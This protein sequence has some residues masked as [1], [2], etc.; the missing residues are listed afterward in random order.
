MDSIDVRPET[1]LCSLQFNAFLTAS[2]SSWMVELSGQDREVPEETVREL[3]PF[4]LLLQHGQSRTSQ[5]SLDTGQSV[6]TIS[7]PVSVVS[8]LMF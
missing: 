4:S 6:K 1:F 7:T 3:A 2:M 8:H 5:L